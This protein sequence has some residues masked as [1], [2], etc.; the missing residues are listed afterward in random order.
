MLTSPRERMIKDAGEEVR[1]SR[2]GRVPSV[3]VSSVPVELGACY[4]IDIYKSG[5][6]PLP[7]MGSETNSRTGDSPSALSTQTI[8]RLLGALCQEP[9]QE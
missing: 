9:G 6:S 1:R 8:A 7:G 3:G 4:H 5:R 2:S